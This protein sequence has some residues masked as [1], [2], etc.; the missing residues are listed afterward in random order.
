MTQKTATMAA[1]TAQRPFNGDLREFQRN[2]VADEGNFP[3]RLVDFRDRIN[4]SGRSKSDWVRVHD[5][6]I[7]ALIG[8]AFTG[9]VWCAWAIVATQ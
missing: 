5:R 7:G 8:I 9:A 1:A 2:G 3:L 4:A 6:A